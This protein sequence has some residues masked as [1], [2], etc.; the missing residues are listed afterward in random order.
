M[1]L[2]SISFATAIKTYRFIPYIIKAEKDFQAGSFLDLDND[3][4]G[5][6]GFFPQWC[7]S[8]PTNKIKI[9]Q[10]DYVKVD[11]CS[12]NGN[13]KEKILNDKYIYG[14]SVNGYEI[15]QK[16]NFFGMH[17]DEY[18]S[19]SYIY[20]QD[21]E[22]SKFWTL[23]RQNYISDNG[24]RKYAELYFQPSSWYAKMFPI[25]FKV[26]PK[27][28]K[29]SWKIGYW[30]TRRSCRPHVFCFSYTASVKNSQ[31]NKIDQLNT[32]SL[33]LLSSLRSATRSF[34]SPIT[35]FACT[36]LARPCGDIP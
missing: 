4:V 20:W 17:W 7:G 22:W 31:R 28:N 27:D 16:N 15:I 34:Q 35:V 2:L 18:E 9:H 11:L 8:W 12:A 29:I 36:T 21:K 10:I 1:L 13:F 23:E 19:A 3:G 5:E 30:L 24:E 33:S 32:I 26:D 14:D 25:S 6:Y